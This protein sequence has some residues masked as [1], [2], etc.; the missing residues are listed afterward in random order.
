MKKILSLILLIISLIGIIF[1]TIYTLNHRGERKEVK[2]VVNKSPEKVGSNMTDN[3]LSEIYS[4]YLNNQ[5]HKLKFEYVITFTEDVLEASGNF[6][7]YLDG[8][9]LLNEEVL[10]NYKATNIKEL[11]ENSDIKDNIKLDIDDFQIVKY[12]NLE[13]LLFKIN[14]N[15]NGIIKS[16]YYMFNDIG[17]ILVNSLIYD[18]S[19]NYVSNDNEEFYYENNNLAK[20]EDNILYTL[21][22]KKGT[23]T[24][25]KYYIKDNELQKEQIN[26]YENIKIKK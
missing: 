26:T 5:K 9:S 24:E 22:Y 18:E 11:F 23:I 12:D 15:L 6:H 17:D 7:L 2:P 20:F 13:Y 3:N 4:L 14:Y 21:E 8:K 25:Y 16:R 1:L 19:L 10:T